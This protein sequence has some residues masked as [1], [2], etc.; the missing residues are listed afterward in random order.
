MVLPVTITTLLCRRIANQ[1]GNVEMRRF[2]NVK[3][4]R[5]YITVLKGVFSCRF[6]Q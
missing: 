5:K 3:K 2:G 4:E 6:A 1:F